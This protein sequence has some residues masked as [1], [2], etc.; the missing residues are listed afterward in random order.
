MQYKWSNQNRSARNAYPVGSSAL[1]DN[2][3][4]A[5]IG[6]LARKAAARQGLRFESTKVF[7][8]WRR[9]EQ[10]AA[11]GKESL[12]GC[13]QNDYKPLM[14]HFYALAG[15]SGAAFDAQL[16]SQ[17]EPKRVA[18]FKLGQMCDGAGV[19]MGYAAA[20]ARARWKCAIDDLEPKQIWQLVFTIKNRKRRAT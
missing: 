4:K 17:M 14:A 6:Q 11:V 12:R 8:A 19:T 9:G 16:M 18:L 7:D 10:L 5:A 20:I 1:L 15:E 2:R 13:S 3:Q